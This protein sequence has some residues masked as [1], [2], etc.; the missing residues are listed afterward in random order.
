[1]SRVVAIV[2]AK[3]RAD[4][5]AATVTALGRVAGIDQVLV[6]DDG[7][8]DATTDAA[9][10]AGATVL[11]LA[12]NRGKGGAVTAAVEA[13]PDA[14]IYVLIDADVGE[15]AAE[16]EVLLAPVLD[17]DADLVIGVLPA[18]GRRG[19]F[20]TIR[21]L[22]TAGIRRATGLEMRAALSG[23]RA[24]RA[25]YLR[26]LPAA[27]RFGLEVAMTIDTARAGGRVREVDVDMD[28]R[29]TGRTVAG[30]G[31]RGRQG[32]DIAESLWPRL[33]PGWARRALLVAL[34][35]GILGLSVVTTRSVAVSSVPATATAE[36]VVVVGIP[37]LGIEHLDAE[38]MPNLMALS[39]EGA[40][41]MMTVRT[42]GGYEP[43]DA[44]ASLGAGARVSATAATGRA[45]G[46]DDDV[47]GS[48]AIDVLERRTGARPD[49]EV[50]VPNLVRLLRGA[51]AH[52]DSRPGALGFALHRAG[53]QT[54]VVANSDIVDAEGEPSPQAPAALAV[55]SS[56][57]AID[58]G[59]VSAGLL[60]DAAELPFGITMD[61]DALA[62][63]V[64]RV[65][66]QAAV[67]VVDFGETDRTNWYRPSMSADVADSALEDALARSD[68]LLGTVVDQLPE[69]TLLLVASMTP[70]GRSAELVPVVAHGAG[71]VPGRLES[72]STG[73][74]GL[75]TL[76][77][78]APTV[79][80]GLGVEVPPAM[81][82]QPL[83][84][85]PGEV[86]LGAMQDQNDR[87]EDRAA[88][89]PT[90][91]TSFVIVAIVVYALAL[92][93][94]LR[95][96][97]PGWVRRLLRWAV[98]ALPTM[99]VA[100]FVLR[101]L[102]PVGGL[103]VAS[104]LLLYA[105]AGLVA[106]ALLGRGRTPLSP[107]VAVAWFGFV[108]VCV[109]LATGAHLQVSSLLG[110]TPTV[111]ARFGGLGNASYGVLAAS[112]VIVVTWIVARSSRPRDALWVALGVSV[113]A[114][115]F[116][117]APWLGSDVGGILSLVPALGLVLILVAGR[118]LSWRSVGL[119]LAAAVAILG[120]VVGYEALQPENERDHI[121]RFFLG[122]GGDGAFWTT[123]GRKLATNIDVLTASTWS[124]L[125]P[126]IAGFVI[127]VLA[128]GN[129]MQR[130]MPRRSFVRIGFVGLI[131]VA[132]L[133]YAMNDSG[134]VVAALVSVYVGAHV[135]LLALSDE[136]VG[137]V[138]D[139][140]LLEPSTGRGAP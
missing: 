107:L 1:M 95:R 116:D 45:A 49:G 21:R 38:L 54:A 128:T 30:F 20:G 105:V 60:V 115:A 93:A 83:R 102:P 57:G 48:R 50:L 28:H 35:V 119:A 117:A 73:R 14:E 94:L 37:S 44:Y 63:A 12:R 64:G 68:A 125:I 70:P 92:V 22:A 81:V 140:E 39:S 85:H 33:V 6:V 10:A 126:A 31:H 78:L 9:R 18:A 58:L 120:V 86:D 8:T 25:E 17:D 13:T 61:A 137:E 84:Y 91:Q 32:L 75:V 104:V 122:G 34:V 108:L 5:I 24:I 123:I 52:V 40:T 56:T 90:F 130:L 19:G 96:D 132:L 109:D 138:P 131:T 71:V 135:A 42:G 4:T 100:T 66:D 129:R 136:A 114:I 87:I 133:G 118:Q 3:D 43:E 46:R 41:G 55:V 79:L 111:A 106:W 77:D 59:D 76:T 15:G 113:V 51:G 139:V 7:S 98:V 74:P 121:G 88:A 134:A 2:P 69:D 124:Y 82:G 27:G 23:Q 11:R 101:M 127:A 36:R 16:A 29:H 26:G 110:Y 80:A 112:T 89:Y 62:A 65:V 99:L 67:T 53:L 47:E 72:P 97:T 103:G